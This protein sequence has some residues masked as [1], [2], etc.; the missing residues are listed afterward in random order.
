MIES[1]QFANSVKT[2]YNNT[3]SPDAQ[4]EQPAVFRSVVPSR[5]LYFIMCNK[6]LGPLVVFAT[7]NSFG[8]PT[9]SIATGLCSFGR[10]NIFDTFFS[11]N[12]PVHTVVR[13]NAYIA[14]CAYA[15]LSLHPEQ[16]T[17]ETSCQ[18][19]EPSE[20]HWHRKLEG[21]VPLLQTLDCVQATSFFSYHNF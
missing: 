11:S 12:A 5:R 17:A 13:P 18:T 15:V 9:G 21:V 6:S 7:G 16:R 19:C 14:S 20:K 3:D 1:F 2:V 10:F 8:W 4:T